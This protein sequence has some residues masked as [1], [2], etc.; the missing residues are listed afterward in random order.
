MKQNTPLPTPDFNSPSWQ[1]A[2]FELEEEPFTTHC[3]LVAHFPVG[4]SMKLAYVCNTEVG[5]LIIESFILAQAAYARV[6][7]RKPANG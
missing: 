1:M 4:V 7:I 5:E 3:W 6:K 2:R